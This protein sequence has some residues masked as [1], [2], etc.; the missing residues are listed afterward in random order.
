MNENLNF[1][2]RNNFA[3]TDKL[4]RFHCEQVFDIE[5]GQMQVVISN[6]KLEDEPALI[7]QSAV[8]NVGTM[9]NEQISKWIND[10]HAINSD[11][12]KNFTKENFY[13]S[14]TI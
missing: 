3:N 9:Q 12:F 14:F 11:L 4:T 13:A 5:I 7:W 8:Y 1:N 10:A 6:G 2:F